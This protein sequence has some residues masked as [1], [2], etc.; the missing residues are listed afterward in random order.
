MYKDRLDGDDLGCSG[1]SPIRRTPTETTNSAHSTGN[2][3]NCYFTVFHHHCISFPPLLNHE[4]WL[5]LEKKCKLQYYKFVEHVKRMFA[6]MI[7]F[8]VDTF[9]RNSGF[10]YYRFYASCK[11]ALFR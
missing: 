10:S 3:F 11:N 6:M 4:V 2:Y 9:S 7:T 1:V 8:L 5:I